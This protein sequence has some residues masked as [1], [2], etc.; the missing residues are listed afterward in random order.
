MVRV[1]G[2]RRSGPGVIVGGEGQVLTAVEH[3]SLDE[4]AMTR[5]LL[6][7]LDNPCLHILGHPTGRLIQEREPYPVR[8]EEVLERAAE[9]GVAVEVNGKPQRLDIKAEYVR[10]AVQRG[11]KLVVS[12][13]AHRT[14][15][16]HNLAFAVATARRGWARKRHILNTL[17]ADAFKAALRERR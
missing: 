10:L 17:P 6:R 16:L 11:V 5:R 15:D 12:A 4:D 3:V 8:M 9:R 2:P 14:T 13:D 1:R 7:A